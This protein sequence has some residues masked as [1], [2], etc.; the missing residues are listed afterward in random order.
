MKDPLEFSINK[1]YST[2]WNTLK[3]L[4]NYEILEI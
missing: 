2:K 3:Q 4:T 1:F